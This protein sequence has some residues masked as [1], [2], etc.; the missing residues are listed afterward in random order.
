MLAALYFTIG[1]LALAI[2][3]GTVTLTALICGVFT[4]GIWYAHKSI[5][6][7]ARLAIEA[8]NNN[9]RWDAEKMANLSRFGNE[10]LKLHRTQAADS[11]FPPLLEMGNGETLDAAFTIQGI[12][13]ESEQ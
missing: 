4:L 6:L 1:G 11:S 13:E 10:V 12:D 2:L 9:D 5:Q 8:Q 7:G 3:L